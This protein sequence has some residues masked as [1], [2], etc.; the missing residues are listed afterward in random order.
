MTGPI[1]KERYLFNH[2]RRL[3]GYSYVLDDAIP[4]AARHR[5]TRNGL[6]RQEYATGTRGL[7]VL[8]KSL[9]H[10]PSASLDPLFFCF[11]VELM[12]LGERSKGPILVIPGLEEVY[13]AGVADVENGYQ[14]LPYD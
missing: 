1:P 5:E 14:V 12:I 11:D 2:V 3:P 7:T 4:D 13:R 10:D 8:V 9:G 6:V